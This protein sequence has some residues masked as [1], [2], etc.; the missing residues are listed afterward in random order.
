MEVYELM[1]YN[2]KNI[3]MRFLLH[4]I[5][6]LFILILNYFLSQRNGYHLN[7][8]ILFFVGE[9]AALIFAWIHEIKKSK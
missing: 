8:I 9:V 3:L 2:L 5:C 7:M 4:S 6:V 1:N